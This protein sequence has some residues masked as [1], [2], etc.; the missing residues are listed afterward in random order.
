MCIY[1]REEGGRVKKTHSKE[2]LGVGQS[3]G[4]GGVGGTG[5]VTQ[6]ERIFLQ[7]T[8]RCEGRGMCA[9]R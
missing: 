7:M 3:V 4:C 1:D 2:E 8:R 6:E 5:K 9:V